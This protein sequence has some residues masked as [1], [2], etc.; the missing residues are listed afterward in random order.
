MK[1]LITG[2]AGGIAQ[3]LAMELVTHGHQVVGIDVRPW[4]EAPSI[5]EMHR[6][7]LR[8]RGI[9]NDMLMAKSSLS[10]DIPRSRL[11]GGAS[12]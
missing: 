4:R 2:I 12:S 1:V 3:K 11:A 7:D 9:T 10:T 5:I 8:K 6:T